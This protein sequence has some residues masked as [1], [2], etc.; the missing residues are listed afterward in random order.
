MFK[1][2]F[3]R[4]M[5]AIWHAV[6]EE[7][8]TNQGLIIFQAEERIKGSTLAIKGLL[9]KCATLGT[10]SS[11]R[12]RSQPPLRGRVRFTCDSYA[13]LQGCAGMGVRS[14]LLEENNGL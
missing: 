2:I 14:A 13:T 1:V 5:P 9:H 10:N 6:P 11:G 4:D 7:W 8:T 12:G 3:S